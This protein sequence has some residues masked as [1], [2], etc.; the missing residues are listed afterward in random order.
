MFQRPNR[1]ARPVHG[2]IRYPPCMQQPCSELEANPTWIAP[3]GIPMRAMMKYTRRPYQRRA[4]LVTCRKGAGA[5]RESLPAASF[6]CTHSLQS[7][8]M[9]MGAVVL[10]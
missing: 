6:R 5:R 1:S 10:P 4:C 9:H 2:Q 3:L 7:G 8:D